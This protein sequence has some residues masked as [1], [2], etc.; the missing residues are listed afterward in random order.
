[1][2]V[3][4]A[5]YVKLKADYQGLLEHSNEDKEKKRRRMGH[6]RPLGYH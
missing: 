1:L 3:S 2:K 6:A 4:P 5:D